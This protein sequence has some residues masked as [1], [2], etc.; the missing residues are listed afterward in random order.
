MNSTFFRHNFSI[1]GRLFFPILFVCGFALGTARAEPPEPGDWIDHGQILSAGSAGA[2][3]EHL[4]TLLSP[5][6]LIRLGDSLYLY[7]GGGTG[8]QGGDARWRKI[9]LATCDLSTDCTL[10]ENWSKH[11]S[12]PI[13]DHR[14]NPDC[15]EEGAF[16][17]GLFKDYDGTLVGYYTGLEDEGAGV[18]GGPI[19]SDGVTGDGHLMT[20][21]DG[22][23]WNHDINEHVLDRQD[24]NLQG[25][26]DELYVHDV[27]RPGGENSDYYVYY[28]APGVFGDLNYAHGP[29][30]TTVGQSSGTV[31]PGGEG[32]NLLN[33]VSDGSGNYF[34][35]TQFSNQTGRQRT[36]VYEVFESEPTVLGSPIRTYGPFPYNHQETAYFYDRESDTWYMAYV[37]LPEQGPPA[38]IRIA[39]A[40][41]AGEQTRSLPPDD[42]RAE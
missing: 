34:F 11:P 26:G 1:L 14:P 5:M 19:C 36:D 2:W 25:S 22:I 40:S 33:I 18:H 29:T 3:D 42:L 16:S 37:D 7:Y 31:L 8:L 4:H 20:S 10:R 12:N 28:T 30:R 32:W 13:I 35:L 9:G 23:V 38:S 39:T 17:A 15:W 21:S 41:G 6:E 27:W 24:S